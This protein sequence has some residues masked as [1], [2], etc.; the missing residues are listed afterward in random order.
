MLTFK[1]INE[2]RWQPLTAFPF[3][4]LDN[5]SSSWIGAGIATS[6]Y[7]GGVLRRGVKF[8]I[9]MNILNIFFK[10][11]EFWAPLICTK[12]FQKLRFTGP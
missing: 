6:G 1:R 9:F 11:R 3:K 8:K 2:N 12:N 10:F 7:G 5:V 4:I